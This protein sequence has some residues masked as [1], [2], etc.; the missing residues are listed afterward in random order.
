MSH[1]SLPSGSRWQRGESP[2]NILGSHNVLPDHLWRS[3]PGN[4]IYS[5]SVSSTVALT[6]GLVPLVIS[7][8]GGTYSSVQ[9]IT[10]SES[11]PG[12]T[13]YYSASGI[14]NTN[15]YVPYTGPI[16]LTEGGTE[17]IVAYATETG[18]Q[19]SSNLFASFTLN[20]P[21]APTPLFSPVSGSYSSTQSVT[22][23]DAAPQ[24]TIYYTTDGSYPNVTSAKY[25]G[26]ITVSSSETLVAAAV[27]YGYSLSVPASAQYIISSSS[28]SFIYT[29]A[30][31]GSYGY[32]GDGGQATLADLNYPLGSVLDKA[33]N[34]YV[35]DGDN[36][37]IRKVAAGTG[38][39]TTFAGNG[40]AGY[41]GDGGAATGAELSY[42]YGLAL[43]GAGNLYISDL[44]NNVIRKVAVTTG[45]ITTYAGN[46]TFG[47]S[48][49]N[50][51][52][53]SAALAYPEGIAI[54]SS[55]NL[56]IADASNDRI[57][58]VTAK[59]AVITTVAGNGQYG[60]AGDGGQA[61]GAEFRYPTGV[62]VD[63]PAIFILPTVITT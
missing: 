53:T 55:G 41:S 18:Y 43:D 51:P 57:R 63:V 3:Y 58:E 21:P 1:F 23:T 48:G 59:T 60:Y 25:T 11:I 46:G 19:P 36:N 8:S 38:V 26:P 10:I 28:N 62:A 22:I 9:T 31:N 50:G 49:D 39:I 34:L 13:I 37:V 44:E 52:A 2:G 14:V 24:A 16:S 42:P 61:T 30:G 40:T 54:D 32:S 17:T 29:V 15:G 5:S 35:A 12:A 7:P 47:Y 56:Y 6:A 45:I 33:G 4:S 20:L 27:A